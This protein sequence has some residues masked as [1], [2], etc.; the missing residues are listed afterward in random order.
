MK[1]ICTKCSEPKLIDDFG[2]EKKSK[3]GRKSWCRSC[4]SLANK[5]RNT[6]KPPGKQAK[7]LINQ[8]FGKLVVKKDLGIMI[9]AGHRR[10]YWGCDCDCGRKRDVYGDALNGNR[11]DC[12]V[13]CVEKQ[14]EG[15][16]S[17][18]WKG[19]GE[20]SGDFWNHIKFGSMRGKNRKG[21]KIEFAI[22]IEY[23]WELFLQQ[24]R[25]CAIIGMDLVFPKNRKERGTAS[26]DRIDSSKGYIEGNVQWTHKHIN[27]MK[28]GHEYSYFLQ[29][30]KAVVEH[31]D[32]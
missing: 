21:R 24:K 17:K 12:C 11:I 10:H 26:L 29:L 27:M 15:E 9:I 1:K 30:C 4:W 16:K 2:F 31:A 19:H 32:K 7:N 8:R 18:W 5:K 20:I 14:P 25:K 22:S 6:G 23:A 3:D 13:E 28:S